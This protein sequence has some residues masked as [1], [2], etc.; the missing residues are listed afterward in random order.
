MAERT[1]TLLNNA[2]KTEMCL[3]GTH[4]FCLWAALLW[5]TKLYVQLSR[6]ESLSKTQS[7]KVLKETSSPQ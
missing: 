7:D 1:K 6:D 4:L 3:C 2:Q 5:T